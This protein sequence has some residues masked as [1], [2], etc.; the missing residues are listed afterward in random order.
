MITMNGIKFSKH[1]KG[2]DYRVHIL[3]DDGMQINVGTGI[4][5][6]SLYLYNELKRTLTSFDSVE[7]SQFNPECSSKKA[8]RLKYL[9]YVNSKAFL[10]KCKDKEIV[11]FTNYAL[12]IRRSKNTKYIVTI[13]D[14]ASFLYPK[15]LPLLY[16]LYN[17]WCIK[18]AVRHSDAILTVSNSVKEE[19]IHRFP[20]ASYKVRVAYPGVYEEFSKNKKSLSETYESES[21]R[22]IKPNKFF[23]F[24]G[25]IEKRKN[26]AILIN[27]FN[28][29][30]QSCSAQDYKLVLAGRF[31]VGSEDYIDI[32]NTSDCSDDIITTGYISSGDC[33][34]LYKNAAAYVFPTV[35]EGFGSTQLE[36]MINHLPLI[37]SSIS[38]NQEI[39]GNY[40]L[41][42]DLKDVSSLVS[43][44]EQIVYKQYDYSAKAMIAD[45]TVQ[46]FL[47][48]NVIGDYIGAYNKALKN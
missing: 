6:Y 23:L 35:Y 42:F 10:D 38:T 40:S 31:G 7:L 11:H 19:I 4:G 2:L 24:I 28:K 26:L 34:R 1:L 45:K 37:C 36:C 3:I 9:F 12:P 5:K 33:I 20:K 27:A 29:L 44:M 14:L 15:T 41:F 30:K 21:L 43:K 25:T 16:A 18:Y 13:H 48:G 39:S 47:W 32:I 8:G 46:K 22:N 17:R